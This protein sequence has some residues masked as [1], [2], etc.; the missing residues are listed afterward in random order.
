MGQRIA[1]PLDDRTV[2]LGAFADHLEAHLLAGLGGQF[3]HQPR[4]ALK[5][6]ADR[7]GAHR[8]H[9][10]LQF[11]GMVDDLF[12]D[13]HQPAADILRQVLHDLAKHGLRDDQFADHVDDAIDL[14]EFDARGGR[15]GRQS[16][17]LAPSA[18]PF[19]A[20]RF[21]SA[22]WVPTAGCSTSA[23]TPVRPAA[24]H[25]LSGHAAMSRSRSCPQE[26]RMATRQRPSGPR[27]FQA[28]SRRR[29]IRT[30][31][32]ICATRRR[33]RSVPVQPDIARSGSSSV[34]SGKRSVSTL[35]S[36]VPSLRSSRR[37]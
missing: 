6:R 29:R 36:S 1:Q 13:L 14:F 28:R 34:N 20:R 30:L 23:P 10:V 21:R 27:R 16:L 4:H 5:H 12:E 17:R 15:S 8:H 7:L 11:A 25:R 9:A 35:S 37:M 24:Q 31:R 26:L 22:N 32:R 19:P 18:A 33:V 2:D 3:A